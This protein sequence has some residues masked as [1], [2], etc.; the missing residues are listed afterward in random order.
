[1]YPR[2]YVEAHLAAYV[3]GVCGRHSADRLYLTGALDRAAP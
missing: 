3:F 2:L 1:M